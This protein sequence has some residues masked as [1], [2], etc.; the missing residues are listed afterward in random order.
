MNRYEKLLAEDLKDPEVRKEMERLEPEFAIV[1]AIIDARNKAGLTQEELSKRSGIN[2]ANISKL[3][4]G[5]A[6]PSISTLQKLAKGLGKKLVISFMRDMRSR[7]FLSL[8]SR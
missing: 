2:Q 5:N 8:R 4:N 1:R 3:E 6:N 7:T